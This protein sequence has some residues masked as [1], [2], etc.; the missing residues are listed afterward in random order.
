MFDNN[1]LLV[2]VLG[3]LSTTA[4]PDSSHNIL[5][6]VDYG[7]DGVDYVNNVTVNATF[8]DTPAFNEVSYTHTNHSHNH[9]KVIR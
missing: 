1:T 8:P 7:M 9:G 6:T 3:Q 5:V 2:E 4:T